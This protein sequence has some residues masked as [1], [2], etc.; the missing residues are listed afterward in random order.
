MTAIIQ[1]I[2]GT[3]W[4]MMLIGGIL[5]LVAILLTLFCGGRGITEEPYLG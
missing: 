1:G 2:F 4:I 5:G 3:N